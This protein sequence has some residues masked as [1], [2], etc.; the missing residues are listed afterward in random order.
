MHSEFQLIIIMII[1][2]VFVQRRKVIVSE[3]LGPG[4]VLLSRGED[5]KPG[6]RGM[7]LAR[8]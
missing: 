8:T 6:R 7:S 2:N 4:S 3:S 5:R 1:I